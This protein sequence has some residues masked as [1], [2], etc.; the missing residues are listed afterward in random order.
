MLCMITDSGISTGIHKIG[1]FALQ[2]Q[3]M[4]INLV[5]SAHDGL[6]PHVIVYTP[7]AARP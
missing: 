5:F 2:A 4:R 3:V 1:K 6:N 7:Q